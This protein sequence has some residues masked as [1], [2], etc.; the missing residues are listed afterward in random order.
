M[1]TTWKYDTLATTN[2]L[3]TTIVVLLC[4]GIVFNVLT[5][6]EINEMA[7]LAKMEINGIARIASLP[8]IT[9]NGFDKV[10]RLMSN[11]RLY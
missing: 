7:R 9:I 11:M 5:F 4:I 6:I 3:L 1:K 2:K 10:L 8:D